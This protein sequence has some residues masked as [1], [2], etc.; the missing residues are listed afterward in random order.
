MI[1]TTVRRPTKHE[2]IISESPILVRSFHSHSSCC[3]EVEAPSSSSSFPSPTC[4]LLGTQHGRLALIWR[5]RW[6]SFVEVEA[7]NNDHHRV[8]VSVSSSNLEARIQTRSWSR[9]QCRTPIPAMHPKPT[10]SH[11]ILTSSHA[12][13][14]H[15][16][17]SNWK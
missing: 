16:P 2:D 3:S 7:G 9:W 12:T 14:T 4:L 17:P 6:V 15:F 1:A 5:H 10:I 8:S 11:V 13:L